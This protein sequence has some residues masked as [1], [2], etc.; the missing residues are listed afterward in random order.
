MHDPYIRTQKVRGF[1]F[2][3]RFHLHYK[4]SHLGKNKK[5]HLQLH[6]ASL[7]HLACILVSASAGPLCWGHWVG[8]LGNVPVQ[9]LFFLFYRKATEKRI[10][11]VCKEEGLW[12]LQ[13]RLSME[14][15]PEASLQTVALLPATFYQPQTSWAEVPY[16]AF[17][18]ASSSRL[19]EASPP[20]PDLPW[21]SQIENPHTLAS[22]HVLRTSPVSRE[23]IHIAYR[24]GPWIHGSPWNSWLLT[25]Q[26][27]LQ[28]C[29]I[30]AFLSQEP[31]QMWSFAQCFSTR[32]FGPRNNLLAFHWEILLWCVNRLLLNKSIW[33]D[34]R[35]SHSPAPVQ[36]GSWT[37]VHGTLEGFI[38]KLHWPKT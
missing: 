21:M 18:I 2:A 13:R 5:G 27:D 29:T 20:L 28:P 22:G 6:H 8:H 1:S 26:S 7:R 31:S 4:I 19:L 32:W 9:S 34:S 24:R 35:E 17:I 33:Q 14:L 38:F 37:S 23:L 25:S 36:Q 15:V 16:F 10:L 12:G 30:Y 3:C 11:L